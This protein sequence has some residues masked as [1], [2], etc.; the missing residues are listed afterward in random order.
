MFT[1]L[2]YACFHTADRP[3]SIATAT[4]AIDILPPQSTMCGRCVVLFAVDS[5]GTRAFDAQQDLYQLL[6]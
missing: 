3:K 2:F 5:V 6:L 1:F 4:S